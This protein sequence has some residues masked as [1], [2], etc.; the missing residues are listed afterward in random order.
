MSFADIGNKGFFILIL[1]VIF[2][3]ILGLISIPIDFLWD[4]GHPPYIVYSDDTEEECASVYIYKDSGWKFNIG[5]YY[6]HKFRRINGKWKYSTGINKKVPVY[7]AIIVAVILLID[8][9]VIGIPYLPMT[10]FLDLVFIIVFGGFFV[11]VR[12]SEWFHASW[13]LKKDQ[14]RLNSTD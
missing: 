12:L 6:E 10:L 14:K 8:I 9:F 11:V 4:I 2:V 13:I 7:G 5:K 1:A 3:C